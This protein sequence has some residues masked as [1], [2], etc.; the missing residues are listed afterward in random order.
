MALQETTPLPEAR[1][2]RISRQSRIFPIQARVNLKID[3]RGEL[4]VLSL[5]ASDR[6][7]LLYAVAKVLAKY[8]IS[9][10]MARI[11]TLGERV[12]DTLLLDGEKLIKQ[13]KLQLQLETDLL[14]VLTI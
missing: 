2:G 9:L 11:N 6:T 7:G 13:P 14:E 8:A 5:S 3:D 10:R 12:E 4:F 1:T